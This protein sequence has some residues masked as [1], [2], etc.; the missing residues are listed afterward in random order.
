[1][2]KQ[3][4]FTLINFLLYKFVILINGKQHVIITPDDPHPLDID[5]YII[6]IRI[7]DIEVCQEIN[8]N[9]CKSVIHQ[10][11]KCQQI[12]FNDPGFSYQQYKG[13]INVHRQILAKYQSMCEGTQNDYLTNDSFDFTKD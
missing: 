3:Y 9:D 11:L 1:M 10:M 7:P 12:I 8:T 13:N 5:S 2:I 6:N 4:T